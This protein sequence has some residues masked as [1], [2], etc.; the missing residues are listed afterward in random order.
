MFETLG[1]DAQGQRLH[2]GDG[3]G[4]VGAVAEHSREVGNLGN[5]PAI[6]LAF[7]L[8]LEGT[9][10]PGWLPARRLVRLTGPPC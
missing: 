8:N 5:P 2:F 6:L 10:T 1:Q 3:F 4:L 7:E 9:L